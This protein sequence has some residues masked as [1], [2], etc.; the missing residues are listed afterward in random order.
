MIGDHTNAI[1][2]MVGVS[3]LQWGKNTYVVRPR[4]YA[5]L[6]FRL[7]GTATIECGGE[8]WHIDPNDVWY[9][10]QGLGYTAKYTSTEMV[11]IHFVTERDDD[12]PEKFTFAHPQTLYPL[13]LKAHRLWEKKDPG[14]HAHV[15]ATLYEI[16][17]EIAVNEHAAVLPAP[18]V[19]AVEYLRAHFRE[20]DWNI[21]DVCRD[22]GIGETAFRQRFK[23]VYHTTPADYVIG[24][25]LEYARDLIA[26][27]V[28]VE[29]AAYE[30]GFNDP[31]YFARVVKSRFGCSPRD[32]KLYGK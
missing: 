19:Q 13:F 14:Y 28:S 7:K 29:T 12:R 5:A 18:F 2:R 9:F 15:M 32:L 22:V 6:A 4:T 31:K 16:L 1:V 24:L 26:S 27:G 21:G 30:S 8:T 25:R 20:T 11:A 23:T 3:H 17:G 10:P